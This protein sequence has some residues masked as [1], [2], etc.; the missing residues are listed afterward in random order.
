[1]TENS[2][3]TEAGSEFPSAWVA[4]ATAHRAVAGTNHMRLLLI[5]AALV[6]P[7]TCAI[8]IAQPTSVPLIDAIKDGDPTRLQSLLD[9]GSD[10]N[11]P[12]ADGTTALHWAAHQNNA[13][14]AAL[15]LEAGAETDLRNNDGVTALEAVSGPWSEE[16]TGLYEFFDATFQM[17][18]DVDRIREVRPEVHAILQAAG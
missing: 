16:L 12:A 7:L 5:T 1:M 3:E 4:D 9:Q 6:V 11:D 17:Q 10:V 13:S 18:L 14:V 2:S 8:A 15:L